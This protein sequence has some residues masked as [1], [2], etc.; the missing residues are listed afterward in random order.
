MKRI[1]RITDWLDEKFRFFATPLFLLIVITRALGYGKFSWTD[2]G[3]ILAY[4]FIYL[5]SFKK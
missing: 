3:Y 4:T 2:A 1:T 5:P